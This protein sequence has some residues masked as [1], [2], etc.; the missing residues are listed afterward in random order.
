MTKHDTTTPNTAS[1]SFQTYKAFKKARPLT[2]EAEQRI[3]DAVQKD[4]LEISLGEARSMAQMTQGDVAELLETTQAQISRLEARDDHLVSTLRKYVEALGGQ[5]DIVA[6]FG[7]K[8]VR[9][10]GV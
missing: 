3:A 6:R 8:S 5:L 4:L 2:A 10:R 9:L 7:D 1:H